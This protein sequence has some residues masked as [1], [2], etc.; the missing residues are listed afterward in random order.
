MRKNK[1]NSYSEY[2]CLMRYVDQAVNIST[3]I[4]FLLP[5][6]FVTALRQPLNIIS[7]EIPYTTLS[8]SSNLILS[9]HLYQKFHVI[10]M[11]FYFQNITESQ[12]VCG[13]F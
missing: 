12:T 3:S 11:H 4:V 10:K 13:A 6:N 9:S 5:Q 7:A 8:R 1:E 2:V